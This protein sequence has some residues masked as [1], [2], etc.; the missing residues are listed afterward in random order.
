[1]SVPSGQVAMS[2][3]N[4]ELG[5]EGIGYASLA[6]ASTSGYA[7]IN[8]A[9]TFK[10]DQVAP[11]AMS[12]WRSYNHSA[13]SITSLMIMD[14]LGAPLASYGLTAYISPNPVGASAY[15]NTDL[16]YHINPTG[17]TAYSTAW[18][19][20]GRNIYGPTFRFVVNLRRISD[21]IGGDFFFDI[22][23][24]SNNGVTLTPS[25]TANRAS[26]GTTH[27]AYTSDVVSMPSIQGQSGSMNVVSR[28][29]T[30]TPSYRQLIRFTY[31]RAANSVS[32]TYY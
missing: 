7:I 32:V 19:M 6:T 26:G 20:A 11:H 21:A 23:G 13:T 1:M 22:Y 17:S 2:D 5:R 8:P 24:A 12:E 30:V 27:Y 16:A 18:A 14:W 31:N 15:I 3:I 29:I 4:R 25:L 28:S 9:S 10:P